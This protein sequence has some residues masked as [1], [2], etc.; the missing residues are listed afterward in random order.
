VLQTAAS[1]LPL[2]DLSFFTTSAGVPCIFR[3]AV[4]FSSGARFPRTLFF[5]WLVPPNR[6]LDHPRFYFS[7]SIIN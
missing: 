6:R 5:P 3:V 4:L 7:S 2:E 1:F